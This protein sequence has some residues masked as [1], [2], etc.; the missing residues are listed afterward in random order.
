MEN[1]PEEAIIT[2]LMWF[3]RELLNAAMRHPLAREQERVEEGARD[4]VFGEVG[5]FLVRA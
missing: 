1:Q 5:H 3:D 4:I 2:L